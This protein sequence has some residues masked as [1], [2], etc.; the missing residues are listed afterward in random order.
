MR[1]TNR[2][3]LFRGVATRRNMITGTDDNWVSTQFRTV[4]HVERSDIT[5][6]PQVD[7]WRKPSPYDCTVLEESNPLLSFEVEE[8]R[9]GRLDYLTQEESWSRRPLPGLSL[10]DL[11]RGMPSASNKAEAEVKALNAVANRKGKIL[12]SAAELRSSVKTLTDNARMLQSFAIA[13]AS[14][15]WGAAAKA[16]NLRSRDRRVQTARRKTIDAGA[17]LGSA[18]LNYSFGISPI[19]DDMVLALIIIKED[20]TIRLKG[21]GRASLRGTTHSHSERLRT[22]SYWERVNFDADYDVKQ[23]SFAYC[24]LWYSVRSSEIARLNELGAYSVPATAWALLPM[25]FVVDWVLPVQDVLQ[26][27]TA[28]QGLTFR[29]GSYTAVCKLQLG[30]SNVRAAVKNSRHVLSK[31][32]VS[33][34]PAK[35]LLMKRTVYTRAPIPKPIYVKDPLSVFTAVTSLALLAGTIQSLMRGH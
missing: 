20:R 5:I 3:G 29:G 34:P 10:N 31:H 28:T 15:N 23:E 26:A 18:W 16:L 17:G 22:Q 33:V 21:S 13:V 8:Y 14:R 30:N 35:C 7:G 6:N 19:I 9:N 27:L 4:S 2:D 1:V 11:R 25:S 24:N 12:E 32:T